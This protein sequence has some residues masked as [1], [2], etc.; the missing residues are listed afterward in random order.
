M[1]DRWQR[2]EDVYHRALELPAAERAAF[3]DDVCAD[4]RELRAELASLLADDSAASSFMRSPAIEQ[5]A[6]DIAVGEPLRTGQQIG[7]FKILSPA[8]RGAMGAVYRARDLKLGRDV[9][10]KVLPLSFVHDAG[11]VA[12]FD[13]EARV[14]ATLNHPNIATIYGVEEVDERKLL[15]LEFVEGITLAERL[16][17][18]AIPLSEAL[19]LAVQIADALESAHEHGIVHRDLKPANIKIR[20]DGMVKVLDFGLAKQSVSFAAHAVTQ[21]A[22]P[23]AA[24]QQ[25]TIVGTA[26]YMAP[27]QATGQTADRR[28]ASARRAAGD[29]VAFAGVIARNDH[30]HA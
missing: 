28:A 17:N 11:R 20:P 23:E 19:E 9:A 2:I 30:P 21:S 5:A 24:T 6:R 3:L 13:L 1:A 14:L 16:A 26:A 15:V 7:P 4:D 22:E 27:E 25:G 18:G 10:V 12:R 29:P 8:G